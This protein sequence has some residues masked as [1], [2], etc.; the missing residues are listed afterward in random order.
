MGCF[1]VTPANPRATIGKP[2]ALTASWSGLDATTPYLG[3][4]QYPDG[5]GTIVTVN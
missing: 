5:S 2:I 4:I 1:T 3:W